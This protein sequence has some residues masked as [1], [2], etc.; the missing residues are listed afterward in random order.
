LDSSLPL[1]PPNKRHD[2]SATNLAERESYGVEEQLIAQKEERGK[3]I[4][5]KK[6][7]AISREHE[8]MELK[9]A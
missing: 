5:E 7:E 6:K 4:R 2:S 9:V 3:E 8:K 1:P